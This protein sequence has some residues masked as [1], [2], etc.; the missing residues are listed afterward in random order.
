M[1][2]R[3]AARKKRR[4]TSLRANPELLCTKAHRRTIDQSL[5]QCGL[6]PWGAV[7]PSHRAVGHI[8]A[9]HQVRLPGAMNTPASRKS[10]QRAMLDAWMDP[11]AR[12]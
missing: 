3:K 6:E 5:Q 11:A 7:P 1:L 8:V 12:H 2:P 10:A 4:P 9:L